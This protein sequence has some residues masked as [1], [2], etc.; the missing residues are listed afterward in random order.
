MGLGRVRRAIGWGWGNSGEELC[1]PEEIGG[2]KE[3]HKIRDSK[4]H[5]VLFSFCLLYYLCTLIII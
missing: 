3:K 5:E 1:R 2:G 4:L